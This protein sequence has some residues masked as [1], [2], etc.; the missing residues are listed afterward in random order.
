MKKLIVLIFILGGFINSFA[1]SSTID[2]AKEVITKEPRNTSGSYPNE[3]RVSTDNGNANS[4]SR[5]AEISEINKRYD[6]KIQAVRVNPILSAEEKERRIRD[7]EYER[8]QK[9]RAINNRY[10]GG[11]NG[12]YSKNKNKVKQ[13]HYDK[14]DN[15]GKKLGWEK[16]KGNPHRSDNYTKGKSKNK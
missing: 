9:V 5:E 1:Q 12:D 6:A 8:A 15:P 13:K 2:K 14:K 11:N 10:Y 16:G 4:G 3:R 7:L